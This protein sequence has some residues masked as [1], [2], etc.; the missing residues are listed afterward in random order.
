M[1]TAIVTLTWNKLNE[2]TIPFLDSL[3]TYTDPEDFELIIVD[4][5]SQDGTVDYL[6]SQVRKR[7]NM[8]VLFNKTNLGYSK[9]NNQGLRMISA[10]AE[11]IG[12]LNNDILF[13]PDW[14]TRMRDFLLSEPKVGLASH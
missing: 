13:T 6:S 7:P 1:K 2:A 10:D 11:I 9:G 3:Y 8:K 4:N 5:G 12:L 14:L